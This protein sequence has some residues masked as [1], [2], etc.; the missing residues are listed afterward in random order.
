MVFQNTD[1]DAGPRRAPQA[2][3]V[4]NVELT[5]A[6]VRILNPSHSTVGAGFLVT[7]DGLIATCAHVVEAAGA[8]QRCGHRLPRR[9]R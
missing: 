5:A 1:R 7:G 4:M 3:R 8:G 2:S 9:R 6:I